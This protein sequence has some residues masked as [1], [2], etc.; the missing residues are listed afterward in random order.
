MQTLQI[1][2]TLSHLGALH[3]ALQETFLKMTNNEI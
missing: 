3:D 2:L 1:A